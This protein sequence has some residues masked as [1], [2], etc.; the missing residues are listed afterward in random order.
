MTNTWLAG[1]LALVL[2]VIW[3][4]GPGLAVGF[5]TG[6]RGLALGALAPALSCAALGCGA[7]VA[8]AVGWPWG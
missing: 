8:S 2:A 1:A 7:L 3:L 5:A 4:W 6:L